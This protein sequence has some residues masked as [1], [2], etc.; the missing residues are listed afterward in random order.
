[1][2][3]EYRRMNQLNEEIIHEMIAQ[4][5]MAAKNAYSPYSKFPVGAAVLSEDGRIFAGCNVENASFGMT[6]CAERNAIF[7]S[8]ARGSR[9]V[10]AVVIYTPTTEPTA[11]CGACRQVINEFGTDAEVICVCDSEK[12]ARWTLTQLLTNAFGPYSF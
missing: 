11:P 12:R 3:Y 10:R 2:P 8:I 7:Q 6:I 1:L 9:K 5:K 4:A